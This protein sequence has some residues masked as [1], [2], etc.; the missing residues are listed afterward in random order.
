MRWFAERIRANTQSWPG[1]TAYCAATSGSKLLARF[2]AAGYPDARTPI[3]DVPLVAVD[4]ETTGLDPG[5][6]AIVSIAAV[7]FTLRRIPLVD[8]R[9]WL[10]RPPSDLLTAESVV[11]HHITHSAL[12]SAPDFSATLPSLLEQLRGR[13]AVVH[14]RHME[15]SFLDMAVRDRLGEALLFPVIDT[16]GLEAERYRFSV[17][18]RLAAF[19]GRQAASIRLGDSRRR[20]GL[21]VYQGHHALR[22]AIATAELFQAQV[23][24]RFSRQTPLGRLWY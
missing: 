17:R 6:D 20:Y 16:M 5:H 1:Y 7:P 10:V 22:D 2:H 9:Y 11:I 12:E 14:Y 19:M 4:V 23:A 15:R 13:I 21:P 18:A 8:R 24:W 3:E